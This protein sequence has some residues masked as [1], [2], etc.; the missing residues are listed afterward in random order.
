VGY[1]KEGATDPLYSYH[2]MESPIAPKMIQQAPRLAHVHDFSNYLPKVELAIYLDFKVENPNQPRTY[3]SPKPEPNPITIRP[4]PGNVFI[5][6]TSS[7]SNESKLPGPT[8]S[9]TLMAPPLSC[10]S[11]PLIKKEKMDDNE[12]T[13]LS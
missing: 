7:Q 2:E 3:L 5:E 12:V 11:L 8:T 4:K 10:L 9:K 6:T 13:T 1:V